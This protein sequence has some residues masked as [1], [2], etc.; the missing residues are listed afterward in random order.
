MSN[1]LVARFAEVGPWLA[2]AL[3]GFTLFWCFISF[4]LSRLSGWAT[5]AAVYPAGELLTPNVRYRWQSALMNANTKYNAALTIVA[6]GRAVHFAMFPLFKVGHAPLSVPWED[7][8]AAPREL[9]FMHRIALTF[10]RAPHVTMLIPVALA[11]RLTA[12]SM[13]RFTVQG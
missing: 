6:D 1:E 7:I 3:F 13:G 5:L 2:L 4:L 10:A 8:H 11:G 12:A 9:L